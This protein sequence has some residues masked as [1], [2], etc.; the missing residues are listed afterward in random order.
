[1]LVSLYC[2]AELRKDKAARFS[3]AMPQR[4]ASPPPRAMLS[5]RQAP[6]AVASPVVRAKHASLSH[7]AS[8]HR[9]RLHLSY[10]L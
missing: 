7:S 2:Y 10:T 6:G 8:P 4:A 1:M 3:C 9:W 5:P